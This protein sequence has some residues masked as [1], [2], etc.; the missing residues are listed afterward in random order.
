MVFLSLTTQ[1]CRVKTSSTVPSSAN[2]LKKPWVVKP[3]F[4]E[5]GISWGRHYNMI[6][7]DEE[8]TMII[9]TYLHSTIIFQVASKLVS[10]L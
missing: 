1:D 6:L 9:S 5:I 2:Y 8:I 3:T 7:D 4:L 10:A